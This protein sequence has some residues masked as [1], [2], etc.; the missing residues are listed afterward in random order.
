MIVQGHLSIV[1]T[2]LIH[3]VLPLIATAGIER[4]VVLHSPTPNTPWATDLPLT[5]TVTRSLPSEGLS[6]TDPSSLLRLLIR[7]NTLM[8]PDESLGE[9]ARSIAYFDMSRISNRKTKRIQRRRLEIQGSSHH[10][11][12]E[13]VIQLLFELDSVI[14]K[15]RADSAVDLGYQ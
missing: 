5:P 1:N 7:M 2:T 8:E 15:P 6:M 10:S 12:Q 9:V 3:P 14:F 4:Q 13:M 11:L